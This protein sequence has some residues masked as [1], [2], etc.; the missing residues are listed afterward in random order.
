MKDEKTNVEELVQVVNKQLVTS[1]V[2]VAKHFE[3]RHDH[4]VRHIES[5][6]RGLPQNGNTPKMYKKVQYT[7]EQ[8]GQR[9]SCYL[10]NRDGFSLLVMSFTGQKALAWKLKFLAAFNAM[11]EQLKK[12]VNPELPD[13][14]NPAVAARA[15]ADQY[16]AREK[17]EK[18]LEEAKPKID[19]ANDVR[20]SETCITIGALAKLLNQSGVPMGRNRLLKWMREAGYLLSNKHDYNMPA[21]QYV[22]QG[23]F[24][25][26][27][28]TAD[29]GYGYTP[30]IR[31]TAYV[32]GKGQQF[33]M[34][35]L[36]G[37]DSIAEV[38]C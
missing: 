1:S 22:N 21:Q 25:I 5:V 20:C 16:E 18:E 11:E 28:S 6:L 12:A 7:H 9:Y 29:H 15:W 31:L 30:V 4:V 24:K 23:L 37:D 19:F 36:K 3:K 8:N 32:T 33:F 35:K 2:V 38:H 10:M 26:H 14:N 27:E 34:H 17:A 13:F